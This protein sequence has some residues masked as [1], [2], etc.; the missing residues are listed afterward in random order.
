MTA[1]KNKELV[2]RLYE[3]VFNQGNLTILEEIMSEDFLDHSPLEGQLP[4]REGFRHSVTLGRSRVSGLRFAIEES[5]AERDL[6]AIRILLY[7]PHQEEQIQVTGMGFFRCHLNK[8]VEAWWNMD[9][10][11]LQKQLGGIPLDNAE[12]YASDS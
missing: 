3:E 4:G 12:T 7:R 6:V 11:S 10:L 9:T 1:E 2:R 5:I 8:I